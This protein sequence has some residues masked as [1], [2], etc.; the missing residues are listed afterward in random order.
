MN[1]QGNLPIDAFG[2]DPNSP[3][4]QEIAREHQDKTKDESQAISLAEEEACGGLY[5]G[6]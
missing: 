5:T 1:I 4:S 6:R 3:L 2:L